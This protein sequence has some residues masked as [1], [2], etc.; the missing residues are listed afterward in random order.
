MAEVYLEWKWLYLQSNLKWST[1]VRPMLTDYE[2][3][4]TLLDRSVY[5]IR[6]NPPF[7]IK[8]PTGNSP[9]VYIGEGNFKNRFLAHKKTWIPE[10]AEVL[11]NFGFHIGVCTPRIKNHHDIHKDLEAALLG[12]FYELYSTA[13]LRNRQYEYQKKSYEFDED[14][15]KLAL[16]IGRGIKYKW[17]I[18]PMK[19]NPFYESFYKTHDRDYL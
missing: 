1:D 2:V 10:L 15:L 8:Y 4:E 5:V 9:V 11:D 13:P 19:N 18:E 14:E 16:R 3:D 12:K 6:L 7:L 17:A